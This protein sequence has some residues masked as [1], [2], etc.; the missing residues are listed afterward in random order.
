MQTAKVAPDSDLVMAHPSLAVLPHTI[1][2]YR[3]MYISLQYV[4]VHA[5]TQASIHIR[6][7]K[8]FS[9]MHQTDRQEDR[10]L[11]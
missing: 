9:A 11:E 4:S 8:S 3:H 7:N 2:M 1:C 6:L 5:V 10:T